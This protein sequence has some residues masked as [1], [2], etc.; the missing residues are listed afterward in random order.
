MLRLPPI[1]NQTIS[2]MVIR[3]IVGTGFVLAG[4]YVGYYATHPINNFA[5]GIAAA[6]FLIGGLIIDLDDVG[7]ALLQIGETKINVPKL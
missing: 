7:K 5:L 3:G 6:L 4:V 1:C 2:V